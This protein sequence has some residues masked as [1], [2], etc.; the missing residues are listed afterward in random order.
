[1][2]YYDS[3]SRGYDE[4]HGEEQTAKLNLVK[5]HYNPS[6]EDLVLDVGCGTGISMGFDCRMVGVDP[7]LGLL[8]I[9]KAKGKRVFCC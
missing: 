7:S 4:L 5:E 2:A 8:K 9:A 3:I 6:S 1:M